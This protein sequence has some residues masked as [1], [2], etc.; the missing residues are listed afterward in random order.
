[1]PPFESAE[2]RARP[3]RLIA[4]AT[5]VYAGVLVFATHYPKPEDFL[6]AAAAAD[7][8]LHF[9][10]Y[11][12]L[13]VLAGA[14]LATAGRWS[15]WTA[16]LLAAALAMFGIVDEVTQPLFRRSAEPLDWVFDCIGIAV[17]IGIVTAAVALLGRRRAA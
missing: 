13:A 5:V 3:T 12:S 2:A 16:F 1:M 8:T 10:A 17:G 14:T 15:P 7:K 4:L 6:G 9:I 11:A